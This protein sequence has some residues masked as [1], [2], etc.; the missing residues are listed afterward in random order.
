MSTSVLDRNDPGIQEGWVVS[1]ASQLTSLD[2][3]VATVT[4]SSPEE[5]LLQ[6]SRP[7]SA[8]PFQ[9]GEPV[10]IKYWDEPAVSYWEGKILEISGQD[11]QRVGISDQSPVITLGRR[12]YSRLSMAVPIS[13]QVTHT[14]SDVLEKPSVFSNRVQN[15]SAGGLSFDTEVAL[16]VGDELNIELDLPDLQNLSVGGWIVRSN[17]SENSPKGQQSVA[18]EFLGLGQE[19]ET[20]LL[21]FLDQYQLGPGAYNLT[22]LYPEGTVSKRQEK[23]F[24]IEL[25]GT[26]TMDSSNE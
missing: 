21:K 20:Q 9:S 18:L 23:R 1:I 5:T 15:M 8:S 17:P 11:H 14:S 16:E 19:K 2:E 22:G 6:L 3:R 10:R 26:A 12:K 25:M 24:E 13:C 4:K 7:D